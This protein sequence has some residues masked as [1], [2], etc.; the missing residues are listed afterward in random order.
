MMIKSLVIWSACTAVFHAPTPMHTPAAGT[1][2]PLA[3]LVQKTSAPTTAQLVYTMAPGAMVLV[4][5]QPPASA[6]AQEMAAPVQ[7]VIPSHIHVAWQLPHLF[8]QALGW[9]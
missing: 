8:T 2:R 3:S 4:V 5:S 6:P 7:P 9:L 1:V